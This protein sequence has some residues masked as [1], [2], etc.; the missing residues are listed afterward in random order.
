MKTQIF[1]FW[2][3]HSL[4]KFKHRGMNIEWRATDKRLKKIRTE[5][6]RSL[7]QSTG[8]KDWWIAWVRS[9]SGPQRS[10]IDRDSQR[11]LVLKTKQTNKK[12]R[13]KNIK[14]FN[15]VCPHLFQLNWKEPPCKVCI[16]AIFIICQLICD[17]YHH[18]LFLFTHSIS[19]NGNGISVL[20]KLLSSSALLKIMLKDTGRRNRAASTRP[21]FW[22]HHTD[23]SLRVV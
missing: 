7:I 19:V 23:R 12:K 14:S 4:L 17:G 6:A 16:L 2:R 18:S 13:F 20:T 22:G 11:N 1:S 15:R 3:R 21:G 8:G 9:Q 10:R 5:A